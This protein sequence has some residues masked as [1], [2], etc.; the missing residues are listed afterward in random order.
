MILMLTD[1]QMLVTFDSPENPPNWIEW[2]DV[3]NQEYEFSDDC[4]QIY[5][6]QLV[7]AGGLFKK[8]LWRLVPR[9]QADI[10]NAIAL[11]ND[12]QFVDANRCAFPDL[13]SV[14]AY[15]AERA[16]SL[17]RRS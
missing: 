8:E 13:V 9:G 12:A 3:E 15:L 17:P 2:I 11:A 4:G 10:A 16:R 1:D 7:Q 14:K 6:G 5:D